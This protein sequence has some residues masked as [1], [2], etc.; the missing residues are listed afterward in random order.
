MLKRVLQIT[1]GILSLLPLTFGVL[2]I[3]YGIERFEVTLNSNLDSQFRFLSTWYLGLTFIVWWMIPNIEKHTKLFRIICI[4]VFI[5]GLSRL[6]AMNHSGLPENRF[7]IVLILELLF[8]VLIIWQN[9]VSRK[10]N[11]Q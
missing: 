6:L 4:V 7:I 11:K 9:K 1:I 3:I 5:G 10:I 8:P 2:G